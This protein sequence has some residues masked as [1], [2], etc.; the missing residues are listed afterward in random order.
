[1]A[2]SPGRLI[3]AERGLNEPRQLV[4]ISNASGDA[5]YGIAIVH[6]GL[7]AAFYWAGNMWAGAQRSKYDID[8]QEPFNLAAEKL[9]R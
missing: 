8:H 1:M 4:G 9:L 5:R 2:A 7:H 6:E 3:V